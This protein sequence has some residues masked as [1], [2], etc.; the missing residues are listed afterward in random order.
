MTFGFPEYFSGSKIAIVGNFVDAMGLGIVVPFLPF[1]TATFESDPDKANLWVGMILAGQNFGVF[2]GAYFM[3]ALA[4]KYGPKFALLLALF[5]DAIFF[6]AAAFANTGVSF[7][8]LRIA[9]G[10]SS[11]G[12]ASDT[13]L[14]K[15]TTP[16]NRPRALGL[17]VA[18]T[19]AG[20]LLGGKIEQRFSH[21]LVK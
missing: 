21:S 7:L 19:W 14:V 16:E 10:V 1:F 18:G 5:G 2:I 11:P 17:L 20:V 3:G 13:W 9:A 4:D 8:L 12:T 15:S 6:L